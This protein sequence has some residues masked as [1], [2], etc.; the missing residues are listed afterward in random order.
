M[1]KKSDIN[2]DIKKVVLNFS[3]AIRAKGIPIKK[4][5][6][7]GSYAKGK[8]R[9]ESD[10]DVCVVSPKFGKDSIEELQLLFKIRRGIDSRIEPFP[11][12]WEEYKKTASPI[13][14]EIKQFG[15]EI[16]S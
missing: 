11:V 6:I 7:F 10:I 2:R 15:R 9:P 8:A 12:S 4:M 1:A 16:K 3:K 13:I 14:F 5:V